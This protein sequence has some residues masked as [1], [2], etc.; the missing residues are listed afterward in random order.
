MYWGGRAGFSELKDEFHYPT[1][2]LATL[3]LA[4]LPQVQE[5]SQLWGQKSLS[6]CAMAQ[7]H[8]LTC[9]R[10]RVV[11]SLLPINLSFKRRFEGFFDF[12]SE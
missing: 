3:G 11:A 9:G 5:S 1:F 2:G 12:V 7:N 4:T 10:L 8:C 6:E